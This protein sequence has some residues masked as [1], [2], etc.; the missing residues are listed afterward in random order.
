MDSLS[1]ILKAVFPCLLVG[2]AGRAIQ[3]PTDT[4]RYQLMSEKISVQPRPYGGRK[5]KLSN[6]EAAESIVAAMMDADKAGPSLDATIQSIVHQAGGWSEY[7]AA[8]ALAALEAVL[9]AGRPLSAA[10]Q[11]AYDKAYAA[12]KATEGFAAD[13]PIATEVLIT[14]IAL[15]ILVEL[16]PYVLGWLGFAELGPIEGKSCFLGGVGGGLLWHWKGMLMLL[17]ITG[18]WAALWQARYLGMVPKRSLFSFFQR[19]GMTWKRV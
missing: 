17:F 15:G 5:P 9:K 16:A 18:S 19:L 7:L 11:D 6:D 3:L 1:S 13:H 2:T 12:F 8:K 4:A 14:V 10:M